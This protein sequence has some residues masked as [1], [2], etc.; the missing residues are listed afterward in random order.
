MTTGGHTAKV[1]V[2]K[3][4]NAIEPSAPPCCCSGTEVQADQFTGRLPWNASA[5]R[6]FP[7]L[8]VIETRDLSLGTSRCEERKR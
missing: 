5:C 8:S 3:T 2:G 1:H 6:S 7:R 4:G